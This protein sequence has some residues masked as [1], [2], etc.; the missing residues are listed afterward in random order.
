MTGSGW[1]WRRRTHTDHGRGLPRWPHIGFEFSLRNTS[2]AVEPLECCRDESS[3]AMSRD[4]RRLRRMWF[5]LAAIGCLHLTFLHAPGILWS[6]AQSV[7]AEPPATCWPA[8]TISFAAGTREAVL[9][10]S[11][12][13]LVA[14]EDLP[15]HPY[16]P[17]GE[18]GITIGVGWDLGQHSESELLH[19][20]A[21]LDRATLRQFEEAIQKRGRAAASLVPQ[22]KLID[23]PR[24]ISLSVF[25]SSLEHSYY[26]MTL[27]LFPGAE[28][29]PTE[30]QVALLSVVFN[31]GVL[32]GRDP[33]WSKAKEVDRR[34][35]IRR[36]QADVKQRD[37][38]AIY[39]H[40]GTMKRLWEKS[41]TRGLLYRRRD[42]QHLIRPYV[43]QELH[44][45]EHRDALKAA[46][47]PPCSK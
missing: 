19:A 6:L 34:W 14:A 36:L 1:P 21:G 4:S 11:A 35:E 28:M 39:I 13:F 23:V 29:L 10:R 7:P 20:W 33:D 32:L 25:R 38:F 47:L 5:S 18:S 30:V 27:R 43:D 46:G 22:L 12:D 31:R 45:E 8:R 17:G 41:G 40:L 9:K 3:I 37:L 26:P 44:W 42:E 16:W 15:A 2:A 24:E